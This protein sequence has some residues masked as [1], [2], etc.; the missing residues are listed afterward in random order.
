METVE[1]SSNIKKRCRVSSSNS[2]KAVTTS[3][4]ISSLPSVFHDVPGE[5]D[6]YG[7]TGHDQSE[8]VHKTSSNE[9]IKQ[10]DSKTGRLSKRSKDKR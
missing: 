8:A 9:K 5:E 6:F 3:V 1:K 10:N 7:F 2:D 4:D